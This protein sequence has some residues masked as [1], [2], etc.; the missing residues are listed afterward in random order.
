MG[1]LDRRFRG[2]GV[3]GWGQAHGQILGTARTRV[4]HDHPGGPRSGVFVQGGHSHSGAETK[5]VR[6]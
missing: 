3:A 1:S 4:G 5:I 6:N 2:L